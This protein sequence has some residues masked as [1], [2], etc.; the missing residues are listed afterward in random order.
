[1]EEAVETCRY[2]NEEEI[3]AYEVEICERK[4]ILDLFWRIRFIRKDNCGQQEENKSMHK[5]RRMPQHPEGCHGICFLQVERCVNDL[6]SVFNLFIKSTMSLQKSYDLVEVSIRIECLKLVSLDLN[7]TKLRTLDLSLTPNLEELNLEDCNELAEIHMPAASLKLKQVYL[8]NTKLR[9]LKLGQVPNIEKLSLLQ[10]CYDLCELHMPEGCPKLRF[11]YLSGSKL[12]TLD[13]GLTPDLKSE[14][15]PLGTGNLKKLISIG[16]CACTNL[17]IFSNS[18]Y[19][20]RFLRKLKLEGSIPDVPKDLDWLACLDRGDSICMLKHLK[21]LELKSC[22]LLEK[23]PKDLGQLIS[24]ETLMITNCKLLR[25]IPSI[26]CNIECPRHFYLPGCVRVEKLPEEIGRLECLKELNIERTCIHRLPFSIFPLEDIFTCLLQRRCIVLTENGI[27][28]K[29]KFPYTLNVLDLN[30]TKLRT[31][32]LSLTS[33]LE[34]LNLEDC[35]ELAEIHM[36]AA[37]LKLK[38]IM[39]LHNSKLRS[40]K[41]GQ[42]LTKLAILDLHHS[43]LRTLDLGVTPN[44]LNSTK[45]RKLD[46]SLTSNL[47]EL[48]LEDCN[49]LAEIHM[50]AASLKLKQIMYL[51]N[52]KLRSL[53]FGQVP[54][55]ETLS[56]QCY[57]LC[58]LHMPEGCLKL[59]FHY[60]SG[61]KLS[62]LDTGLTPDLKRLYLKGCSSLV[63]LLD[64]SGCRKT[65]VVK[66]SWRYR[67]GRHPSSTVS[68]LAAIYWFLGSICSLWFLRKLK[69]E[70]SIPEAPK[71]LDRL[72]CPEEVTLLLTYIKYLPDSIC[73]LKHLK[74]LELKSCFLLEK[75]PKDLD[76]LISLETLIITNCKL[77]RDIP[78]SICNIESLRHFYLPGCV[79]VEKL[80]EEIGR[81]E[82]LKE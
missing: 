44:H 82:C 58:E 74:S 71:D 18:I 22:F 55:I 1:M 31:L 37:S 43:R 34:E 6:Q 45:L 10:N 13:M 69:L 59:R 54:N 57:D 46:L 61:S 42:I 30:S 48:N 70:G 65:K 64:P 73:M 39:Y 80:P 36:P 17:R 66:I 79:R 33:N 7:S 5:L 78:S 24:L 12:S 51:H 38:Q 11:L 28:I 49:E 8:H 25:D 72:A 4:A 56:L 29:L 53:K 14:Y 81:L 60:L 32:D 21:S 68:V 50:P 77:L 76:Q 2:T 52:S 75:L 40:L 47:E 15:I 63:E 26:I 35:N 20:L 41:F 9:S 16:L 67:G 23:L 3:C 62:T 27:L 19:S